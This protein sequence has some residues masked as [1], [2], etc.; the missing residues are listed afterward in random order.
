[1]SNGMK[2][3]INQ[4]DFL[5]VKKIL[6]ELSGDEQKLASVRAI[7]KTMTGVRTDGT[8]MLTDYYALTASEIRDSWKVSQCRFKDPNG[9]VSTSGTFIRLIKYGARQL[10]SGVSVKVLKSGGRKIVKHAFIAKMRSDQKVEQVYRRKWHDD[11][12]A[13]TASSLEQSMATKGY[14]WSKR[15]KRWIPAKWMDKFQTEGEFRFRLPVR[16]LYGPRIQ[17]YLTDSVHIKL[18]TDMA[19]ERLTNNMR[20]EVEYLINKLKQMT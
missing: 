7:N 16:A 5:G 19:G 1:M 10:Q 15:H 18:L 13:N 6:S 8:K 4:S 14:V 9:V 20:H 17:D 12:H 11:K 2:I 3:E